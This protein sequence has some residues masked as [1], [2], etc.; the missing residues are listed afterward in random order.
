MKRFKSEGGSLIELVLRRLDWFRVG[1]T[2]RK[3]LNQ[4]RSIGQFLTKSETASAFPVIVKVDISPACNLRC[5]SCVH[6]APGDDPVLQEQ[7]LSGRQR[8]D[9]TRFAEL[10]EQLRGKS[11]LVSLY[12]LG[13]PLA[14]PQVEELCGIARDAGLG[15]HLSTNFSFR[16]SDERIRRLVSCGVT[17]LTIAFDG[18]TQE[19][20]EL[21]RVGARVEWVVDNLERLCAAKRELGLSL[22]TIEVQYIKFQHNLGDLEKAEAFCERIGVDR[23]STFWGT[24]SNY[25]DHGPDRVEVVGPRPAARTPLC[26]WPHF[27]TLIKFNGDVIPCCWYRAGDQYAP[28]RDMRVVGNVFETPLEEIWNS[29]AYETMRAMV[30]DPERASRQLDE[31]EDSFC[32]GCPKLYVTKRDVS[33]LAASELSW[34]EVFTMGPKG[35]P[36]RRPETIPVQI[37]KASTG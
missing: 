24:Y 20:Y 30:N 29:P 9:V 23:F 1:M 8:M 19:T 11:S 26:S 21:T 10:M 3:L 13:D 31:S 14:H 33:W 27:N 16:L 28:S 32:H 17:E 6:A 36:I 18:M 22:P 7:E 2:P 25:V 4:V 35:D 12:Y 34:D 15:V 5:P 37:E